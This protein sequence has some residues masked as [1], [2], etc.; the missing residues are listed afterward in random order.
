MAA[1]KLE[2]NFFIVFLRKTSAVH[3]LVGYKIYFTDQ[4]HVFRVRKL[5]D[6]MTRLDVKAKVTHDY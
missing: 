3:L 1:A 6:T 5:N 2:I 4:I